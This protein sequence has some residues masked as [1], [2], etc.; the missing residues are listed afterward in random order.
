MIDSDSLNQRFICIFREVF[1]DAT[2]DP[3][4][5][6]TA[7]DIENWDSLA[8]IDLIV[9]IEKVFSI[10]FTTR[11]VMGLKNVGDLKA[12]IAKKIG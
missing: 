3:S 7:N 12:L 1:D 9:T 4:D 2:L 6:T 11:E 10:R 8:H 5:E